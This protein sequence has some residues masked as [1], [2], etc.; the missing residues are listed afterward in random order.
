VVRGRWS[1]CALLRHRF[2]VRIYPA[3]DASG[4]RIRLSH[5]SSTRSTPEA[6]SCAA[7]PPMP[8]ECVHTEF[9]GLRHAQL[10]R[11]S[12]VLAV[13]RI[14]CNPREAGLRGQRTLVRS[15]TPEASLTT[16]LTTPPVESVEG[17]KS[18][19]CLRDELRIL[20]ALTPKRKSLDDCIAGA[21][22]EY[23]VNRHINR[24]RRRFPELDSPDQP[25]FLELLR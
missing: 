7:R 12:P 18:K 23:L 1:A 24:L 5:H 22:R 3:F 6:S 17:V 19:T 8:Q 9:S 2:G 11:L 13:L 14:R 16:W 15:C 21:V 20:F 25:I 10:L 4:V